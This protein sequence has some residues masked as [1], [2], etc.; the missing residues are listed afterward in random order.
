MRL[1]EQPS[2]IRKWRPVTGHGDVD[3]VGVVLSLGRQEQARCDRS[4][5]LLHWFGRRRYGNHARVSDYEPSEAK[6]EWSM[7]RSDAG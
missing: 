2:G 5:E 6:L 3:D 4:S 7:L 1:R